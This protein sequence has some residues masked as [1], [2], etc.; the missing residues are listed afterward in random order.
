[1]ASGEI[2]PTYAIS[3]VRARKPVIG[4]DY[5]T[6][7]ECKDPCKWVRRGAGYC[8]KPQGGE[9]TTLAR[10]EAIAMARELIRQGVPP[11]EVLSYFTRREKTGKR[12]AKA[13]VLGAGAPKLMKTPVSPRF[14]REIM[15]P[16]EESKISK[17]VVAAYDDAYSPRHGRRYYSPRSYYYY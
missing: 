10:I 17:A 13:G 2:P 8:S 12:Y 7:A 5:A 14:K 4:C 16:Q 9:N 3:N 11:E 1:M 6:E 15:G